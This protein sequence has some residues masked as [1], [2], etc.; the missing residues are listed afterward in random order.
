[1]TQSEFQT[2]IQLN[3]IDCTV[4]I[5]FEDLAWDIAMDSG[6][7]VAQC[8]VRLDDRQVLHAYSFMFK[9]GE[10]EIVGS[11]GRDRTIAQLKKLVEVHYD[12]HLRSL[13]LEP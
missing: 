4:S 7:P 5:S 1:M 9:R 3:D 13:A 6:V 2:T 11:Y 10:W 8:W 12:Q